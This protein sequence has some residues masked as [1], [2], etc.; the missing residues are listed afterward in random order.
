MSG[1]VA[2]WLENL[3]LGQFA[4]AF[5]E[6]AIDWELLPDVDQNTLKDIGIKEAGFRLRIM[7][8]IATLQSEV[9]GSYSHLTGSSTEVS[10]SSLEADH[11]LNMWSRTPGERKPVTM[12]FADIT[13]STALTENL[14]AE[15][16]TICS[17]EQHDAC[18]K[19]WRTTGGPFAVLW[20]MG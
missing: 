18:V 2:D 11:D 9:S 13:G 16:S 8:G 19:P 12:L 14:D 7:K 10:P 3:G 20:V 15:E 17:M 4:A 6:N 5:E 1:K